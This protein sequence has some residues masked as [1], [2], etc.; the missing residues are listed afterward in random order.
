MTSTEWS[1]RRMRWP[2]GTTSVGGLPLSS[3][4]VS[5]FELR[6]G[7]WAGPRGDGGAGRG[8]GGGSGRRGI[9]GRTTSPGG[10]GLFGH[11][12]R[13]GSTGSPG[14]PDEGTYD[15]ARAQL[16]ARRGPFQGALRHGRAPRDG[17]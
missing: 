9:S 6:A 15:T 1:C 14:R 10:T 7:T 11:A 5:P 13:P 3:R 12:Q 8:R 16:V 4:Q 2:T 17:G